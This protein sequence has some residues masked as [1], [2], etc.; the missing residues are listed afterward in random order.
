MQ[1]DE[2]KQQAPVGPGQLPP[3]FQP[4]PPA[5]L[6]SA[7]SSARSC[8]DASRS[9]RS[10]SCQGTCRIR[11]ERESRAEQ[12]RSTAKLRVKEAVQRELG[13]RGGG[14]PPRPQLEHQA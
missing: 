8:V 1:Q 13:E 9:L 7:V 10:R 4:P 5:A 2:E 12:T 11:K 3:A 14:S 6:T